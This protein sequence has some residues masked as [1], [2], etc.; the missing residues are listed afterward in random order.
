MEEIQQKNELFAHIR[1]ANVLGF[2]KQMNITTIMS[3]KCPVGMVLAL[4]VKDNII[5]IGF[6]RCHTKLEPHWNGHIGK[7]YCIERAVTHFAD[8]EIPDYAKQV[9]KYV[10]RQVRKF[11]KRVQRY[12]KGMTIPKWAEKF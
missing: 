1:K 6:S 3:R 9:P 7:A 11:I 2:N 5:G 4:P 10:R 12:Y 8:E